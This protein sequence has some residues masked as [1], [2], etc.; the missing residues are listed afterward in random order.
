MYKYIFIAVSL[1]LA[2][3]C[4]SGESID[5]QEE[6]AKKEKKYT[7][8]SGN[9]NKSF[10]DLHDLHIE[11]AK[12]NGVGPLVT[13]A[14]TLKYAKK[15]IRIP[16]EL[17]VYK[18]D[19]LK[20]SVPFLTKDAAVLLTDICVNF[21][22]SLISKDMPLYKPIITSITRTDDDVKGLTRRNVNASDNS[23]HRYGTTFDISWVRYEKMNPT[24][25]RTR[26]DGQLKLVLGQVLYDLRER[27]R[28]YIKHERKQACFHITV[29]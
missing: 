14:D 6:A 25:E 15:L 23:A 28:C 13:R 5:K 26:H 9:Y 17:D 22:D 1:I 24:D 8:F 11:V 20:H 10:N 21:R 7:R 16:D 19:E 29:R 4:S 18:I 2:F 3:S 12:K 27:D